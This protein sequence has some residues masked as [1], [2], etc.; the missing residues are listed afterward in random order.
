MV[1]ITTATTTP[2]NP[3][4]AQPIL[5]HAEL[6]AT[7]VSK[8]RH[9]EPFVSAIE[10]SRIIHEHADGLTRSVLFKG[11]DKEI[12]EEIRYIGSTTVDFF[13]STGQ[14]ITNT[15][16]GGDSGDPADLYLTF[17]FEWPH[18]DVEA[19]SQQEEELR[20][21]YA[22]M[23]RQVVPHTVAVAR[24]RIIQEEESSTNL[25]SRQDALHELTAGGGLRGNR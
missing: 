17:T 5:T 8:A 7:L 12:E 3:P 23:G 20:G 19:G 18:P 25:R 16:S 11:Q 2:V 1:L 9:P 6:W 13:V 4:G 14:H 24:E 21:R 10:R 22:A 15:I